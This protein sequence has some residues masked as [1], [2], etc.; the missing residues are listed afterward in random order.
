M[1][2]SLFFLK[3]WGGVGSTTVLTIEPNETNFN[4][5]THPNHTAIQIMFQTSL[6][7]T[8]GQNTRKCYD[9]WNKAPIG[10][11]VTKFN[12][13]IFNANVTITPQDSTSIN[14][15][16]LLLQLDQ[17]L[18]KIEKNYEDGAV[19]QQVIYKDNE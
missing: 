19:N 2:K 13:G 8:Y 15:P 10:G 5:I 12:D 16:N 17:G 14:N 1:K 11:S 4:S 18:Y 6:P 7:E 9:N 3:P